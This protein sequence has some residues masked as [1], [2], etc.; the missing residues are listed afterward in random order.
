MNWVCQFV[1]LKDDR[2][3]GFVGAP[4]GVSKA[5]S[6]F[7]LQVK[8]GIRQPVEKENVASKLRIIGGLG[9]LDV[10]LQ[11]QTLGRNLVSNRSSNIALSFLKIR[12][13]HQEPTIFPHPPPCNSDKLLFST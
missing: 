13:D 3:D 1:R 12:H 9:K 5:D 6:R 10:A 2:S 7:R 8:L 4:V 11:K